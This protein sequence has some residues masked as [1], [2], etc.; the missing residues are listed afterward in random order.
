M[1]LE[2]FNGV[3]VFTTNLI[4]NYD[5]AFKRRILLNVYFEMPDEQARETIWKLHLS[6]KMPLDIE[7][8]AESLAKRFDG[9]SGADIKDMVFYAAL[10]ALEQGKETLDFSVFDYAHSVI[11]ERYKDKDS[12]GGFKVLSTETISEEQYQKEIAEQEDKA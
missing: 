4:K 7:V 3:V 10:Y 6:E 1:E 8:T 9:I 12:E 11:Q 2:R 5:Q